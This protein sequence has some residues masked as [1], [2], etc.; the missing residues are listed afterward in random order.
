MTKH[1]CINC[2]KLINYNQYISDKFK[3]KCNRCLHIFL[4]ENQI[5]KINKNRSKTKN[6][7]IKYKF[8]KLY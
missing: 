4:R 1:N 5:R 7:N 6:Y 2:N 3:G 8:D